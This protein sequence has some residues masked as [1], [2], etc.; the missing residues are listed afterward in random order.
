MRLVIVLHERRRRCERRGRSGREVGVVCCPPQRQP[1]QRYEAV[2][3]DLVLSVRLPDIDPAARLLRL[4][5]L[6]Q[7]RPTWTAAEL[8]ERLSVDTRTIRRDI[9]RLRS[10]GY[11]VEAA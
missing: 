8:A 1:G 11:P 2:R 7:A 6:L 9:S 3:S 4:L 5:S 10:L